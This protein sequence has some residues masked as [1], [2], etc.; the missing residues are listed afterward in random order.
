MEQLGG[1]AH[2]T[3]RATT[4]SFDWNGSGDAYRNDR[5]DALSCYL[6]DERRW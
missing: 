6:F 1:G 2:E 5:T 4:R 3:E